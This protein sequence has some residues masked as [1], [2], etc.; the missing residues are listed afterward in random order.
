MLVDH[1]AHR[2]W[3]DPKLKDEV[4]ATGFDEDLAELEAESAAAEAEAEVKRKAVAATP[5]EDWED[6]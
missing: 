3:D 1:W 5:E 2:F 6:I 4:F